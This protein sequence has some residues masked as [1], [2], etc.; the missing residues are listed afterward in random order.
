[1]V[2]PKNEQAIC[3]CSVEGIQLDEEEEERMDWMEDW[4][5]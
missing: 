2:G 4:M 1:M 5:D 3:T